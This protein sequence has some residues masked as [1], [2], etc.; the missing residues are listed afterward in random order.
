MPDGRTHNFS[1]R[2]SSLCSPLAMRLFEV[3]G[4]KSAFFGLD[5]ITINKV[6]FSCFVFSCLILSRDLKLT[7]G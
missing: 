4:V 3:E 6:H 7:T 5:Y 1:V 2:E